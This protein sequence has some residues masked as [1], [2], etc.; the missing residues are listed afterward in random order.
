MSLPVS[1][2]RNIIASAPAINGGKG[3][4]V[5][6][7]E[8]L[9]QIV[10][11]QTFTGA[12][13]YIVQ[14]GL[15]DN[16][17]WLS[18]LASNFEN[19]KVNKMRYVY[20]NRS[21]TSSAFTIYIASQ[22]DVNDSEFKSVEEVMNY[23]GAKEEVCWKDFTYDVRP[24][25]GRLLRK[26]MVRTDTLPSG[27]DPTAY[28]TALVTICG[29]GSGAVG[30][31]LGELLVEY[32]VT[33]TNPKMNPSLVSA[34]GAF[35]YT[36]NGTVAAWVSQ[37][38][39][40]QAVW[41]E[42]KGF[43]SDNMPQ[44]D[45]KS[46]PAIPS[47]TFP[48]PGAYSIRYNTSDPANTAVLTG[49]GFSAGSSGITIVTSNEGGSAI[50]SSVGKGIAQFCEVI[51]TVPSAKLLMNAVTGSGSNSAAIASYLQVACESL[52]YMLDWF[53][54]A[55][56]PPMDQM[57]KLVSTY[58]RTH[59]VS[60]LRKRIEDGKRRNEVIRTLSEIKADA[61]RDLPAIIRSR[62]SEVQPDEAE[63]SDVDVVE[64]QPTVESQQRSRSVDKRSKSSERK[65]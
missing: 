2:Q 34:S 28:D 5:V 60:N 30:T 1:R 32:D 12:G 16:F 18:Q 3:F 36:Y 23:T 11:V 7:R 59:D 17:P 20:R 4:R 35:A 43:S 42:S 9:Q 55:P 54:M 19:Y 53:G 22:Y 51:T 50:S 45:A 21:S 58:G 62:Q 44:L 37:P 31:L 25:K 15:S 39:G 63:N 49:H 48:V 40:N 38:I 29:V 46:V 26:Y 65:N 52:P 8:W 61:K 57:E 33:F 24:E 64:I 10:S 13:R 27:I 14:P 56:E 6:H 47:I 41:G